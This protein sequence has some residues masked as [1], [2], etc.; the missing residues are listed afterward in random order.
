M[1]PRGVGAATPTGGV[2]NRQLNRSFIAVCASVAVAVAM[3]LAVVVTAS[4]QARG[5]A[6]EATERFE[7]ATIRQNKGPECPG[8]LGVD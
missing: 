7:V 2:M 3:V 6:P 4:A 1:T 5:V 8:R